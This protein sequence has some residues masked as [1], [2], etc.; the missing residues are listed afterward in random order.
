M[1]KNPTASDSFIFSFLRNL[2]S[3]FHSSSYQ[4]TFPPV[5]QEGSLFSIPSPA[6]IVCRVFDD[7][8]SDKC[9]VVSHCSFYLH[10]CNND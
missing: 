8:H 4:F 3:V 9:E 1:V 7:G 10:F 2:H 5:V 6:F